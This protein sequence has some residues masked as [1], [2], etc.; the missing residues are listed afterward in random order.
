MDGLKTAEAVTRFLRGKDASPENVCEIVSK[1]FSG[2]IPVFLPNRTH[3]VFELVCDRLNDFNG[4]NFKLWKLHGGV[5]NLLAQ[6]W[7]LLGQNALDQE[8]RTKCFK[9]VKLVM[10][11]SNVLES[12]IEGYNGNLLQSMFEC[13]ELIMNT[14]YVDVDEYA[15][16]GLFKSYVDL[17]S[18]VENEH[19]DSV[20]INHWSKTIANLIN[21]P[22]QSATYKPTK[23]STARFF[24]EPL[25]VILNLLANRKLE[26]IS[27]TYDMMQ[28]QLTSTV[29]GDENVSSLSSHIEDVA[30]SSVLSAEGAEYFFQEVITNLAS[31]DIE[32]CEATYIKITDLFVQLSE[33]LLGVLARVNRTLSSS[34][35]NKIYDFET[36]KK[37]Q[38]WR[39][40][41]YLVSL[42]PDLALSKWSEVVDATS[43]I[44]YEDSVMLADSLAEGFIRARDYSQF[45]K[46]VYSTAHHKVPQVWSNEEVVSVLCPKVHE[47]SGNQITHLLK[48]FMESKDLQSL[49]LMVRG[50]VLCPMSKQKAAEGLFQD[51]NFCHPGWPQIAYY[52]LCIYGEQILNSQPDILKKVGLLEKAS[53]YDTYLKFRVTEL[54]GDLTLINVNYVKKLILKLDAKELLLFAERWP[55]LIDGFQD[56]HAALF[57]RMLKHFDKHQMI[58]YFTSQSE[59]VYEL[60][61]FMADFLKALKKVY[62]PYRDELFCCFPA[63][64]F[65][66]YFSYYLNMITED[67][68]SDP[69][70]IISRYTLKHILQEPTLS[71]NLEKDLGVLKRFLDTTNIETIEVSLDVARAIWTAHLNTFKDVIS[72]KYVHEALKVTE[73]NLKKPTTGDLALARVILS[74]PL[75]K[76]NDDIKELK[77]ELCYAFVTAIRKLKISIEEQMVALSDVPLD[78]SDEVRSTVKII[79]KEIGTKTLSTRTQAHLFALV[80]KGSSFNYPNALFISSLFVAIGE[81]NDDEV[82][83]QFMLNQ[84]TKYYSEL[85]NEVYVRIYRHILSSLDNAPDSFIPYLI[86]LLSKLA[87]ML[88]K[89]HQ[90]E[91][92]ELFVSTILSISL[93]DN[94]ANHS[95]SLLRLLSTITL[96]LSDHMWIC[97]QFS[98]ELMLALGD[99]IVS[100]LPRS[101]CVESIYTA[102]VQL[103][104]YVVLFHRYRL[105]SR[106]HLII[107]VTSRLMR[108]LGTN[109]PLENS[110]V[111]ASSYSRLLTALSET[112]VQGSTKESDSLTS[113]AASYKKVLRKYAHILIVNYIYLQ[114]TEALANEV[115]EAVLPGIYSVLGLLSRVELQLVSQ[116]LDSQG[117]SYFKSLYGGYRDYGKWKEQ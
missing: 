113:Q 41:A 98:V 110:K 35:F 79:T 74:I 92:T 55:V 13:V 32:L 15:A 94:L 68:I 86:D 73:K 37:E 115:N 104:S 97:T 109:R 39:L 85:P 105:S 42:D 60:S 16:V 1:L 11:V 84:L 20:L 62:V 2:S 38:N 22:H 5:W 71:S 117:K 72:S 114:L 18:L 33:K 63:S 50:L 28:S 7:A 23:K 53:K 95:S 46:K 26:N 65:R 90:A 3:F 61:N 70:N 58:S 103:V 81:K 89:I 108:P 30:S 4:K 6:T 107:G 44:P 76:S 83:V 112:P 52:V 48:H 51:Y 47:L 100:E 101:E 8:V 19:T 69:S 102:V 87:P 93:I 14:G 21:I 25:P 29:F 88:R 10:I 31:K 59:V 12:C 75:A 24:A 66:K 106:Y 91:H 34:F 96:M 64:I 54:S 9:R 36:T 67:A 111:A 80:V 27:T 99:A 43:N 77:L 45:L 116:C 40:I 82:Q 56:I 49:T 57:E 78:A 17:V